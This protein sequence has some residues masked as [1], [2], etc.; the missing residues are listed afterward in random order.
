MS[1][2]AGLALDPKSLRDI[3]MEQAM[4]RLLEHASRLRASDLYLSL[5]RDGA[6]LA[7]RHQ[8]IVQPL[9][10]ITRDEGVRF[11]S[12]IRAV[13]GMPFAQKQVPADGRWICSLPAG[14]RIDLRINTL[15]TLWG[16]DMTVRLLECGSGL[17]RLSQLGYPKLALERLRLLLNSP[18]GL[19]LVTGP[20]GAGKTTTLYACLN[21]LNDGHRKINTIEDPIEYEMPGVH[22]SQVRPE[23]ELDFP[24]L[25]RN[26]LRQ[27]PDII[28]VG[29]IRDSVTA[30]TAVRAANS[31]HLVLA[32][33]HAASAAACVNTML[34]LGVSHRF[35]ASCLLGAVSQRLVRR[36]C[37]RCKAPQDPARSPFTLEDVRAWLEPGQGDRIY[38]ARGCEHCFYDGYSGRIAVAEV[39]CA[40]PPIRQMIDEKTAVAE[41][42][43]KAVELGMI[44][45]H[46][47]CLLALAQ[48]VT[49]AQELARAIPAE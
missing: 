1:E 17:P 26:V 45:L 5:E 2:N 44:D 11:I 20:T 49:S 37:D 33:L 3:P 40:E 34:A 19:L 18:N 46:G 29:E 47:A 31:G 13:A 22:Q 42:Q 41:I 15:P 27:A 32:T 8:G 35:L 10:R 28:M 30:E 9:C 36:L 25:L 24:V 7:V 39:L 4:A 23:L 48:G 6:R 43:K 21:Y 16:E 12:H 38:S 14:K